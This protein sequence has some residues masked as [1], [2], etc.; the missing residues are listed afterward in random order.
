[1]WNTGSRPSRSRS[2]PIHRR[3]FVRDDESPSS[4]A[5]LLVDFERVDADIRFVW[6]QVSPTKPEVHG[7]GPNQIRISLVVSGRR[8]VLQIL[9][10]AA[11]ALPFLDPARTSLC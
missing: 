4:A 2:G 6:V 7:N 1:M 5:A 11:V 8:L 3:T 10:R 9:I